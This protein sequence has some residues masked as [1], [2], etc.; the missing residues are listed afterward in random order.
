MY[1]RRKTLT[2]IG[3]L[4]AVGLGAAALALGTTGANA[5]EAAPEGGFDAQIIGGQPAE[6]GQFPWIV[7]L[8]DAGD[9]SFNYC[10]GQLIAEDVV[11]TAA[12]CTEGTAAADVVIRHGGTDITQT[13]VYE[14]AEIVVAD[15]FDGS[16]MVNDWSLIRLAEPITGAETL[17]LA[18]ADTKDWG[19]LTVAGWGT[20]ESGSTSQDLLYVDVPY[21]T[22]GE[23]DGAYGAEFDDA[24][25]LCAGDLA[26]GGVDSCQGDSGGPLVSADGVLVGIVSWGYGCAE[27]GNPGVYANVGLLHDDITAALAAL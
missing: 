20:T 13:D 11:L 27:A 3:A 5:E 14:V 26:N 10:G 21:V 25:M 16:T 17:P 24:T 1:N 18:D 2:R 8:A 19:T 15:G 9:P 6:E 12:H 7:A 4:A 23:C 22:D